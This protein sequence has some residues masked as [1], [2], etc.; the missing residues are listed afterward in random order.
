MPIKYRTQRHPAPGRSAQPQDTRAKKFDSPGHYTD[1]DREKIPEEDF[2]GPGRTYPIVTQGDV[3]D[4]A[5]LIGHAADPAAVKAKVKAIAKR[6]GFSLP[7]SWQEEEDSRAATPTVTRNAAADVQQVGYASVTRIDEGK[8]EV[9]LTATSERRDSFKT[10]F[11]YEASKAAFEAWPGNVREMHAPKAVGNRVAVHFDDEHRKI[12]TTLRI[13][14][15]A[16]DTWQKLLDG[17]LKGGSIG[18]SN[19]VWEKRV[20]RDAGGAEEIPVAVKYDLVELSLVDN[21]SNPDCVITVVRAA[22][23]LDTILDII[24]ETPPVSIPTASVDPL[25]AGLPDDSPQAHIRAKQAE[26]A[27]I[28]LAGERAETAEKRDHPKQ[29]HELYPEFIA[30]VRLAGGSAEAREMEVIAEEKRAKVAQAQAIATPTPAAP[31]TPEVIRDGGGAGTAPAAAPAAGVT[32]ATGLQ[33]YELDGTTSAHVHEHAHRHADG[34]THAHPHVHDHTH[35]AAEADTVDHADHYHIFQGGKPVDARL[36]QAEAT[37]LPK[38]QQGSGATMPAGPKTASVFDNAPASN[39]VKHTQASMTGHRV[40]YNSEDAAA[41][42]FGIPDPEEDRPTPGEDGETLETPPDMFHEGG[43]WPDAQKLTGGHYDEDGDDDGDDDGNGGGD[44]VRDSSR[45]PSASTINPGSMRPTPG[46]RTAQPAETRLGARNSA[47][48]MDA[49]HSN[50]RDAALS[51]AAA[52]CE[53]CGCPSCKAILLVIAPNG[54]VGGDMDQDEDEGDEDMG[55][56]RVQLARVTRAVATTQATVTELAAAN[57]GM[58]EFLQQFQDLAGAVNDMQATVAD[59]QR[60]AMAQTTRAASAQSLQL[61]EVTRAAADIAQIAKASASSVEEMKAQ[62]ARIEAQPLPGGPISSAME[63]KRIATDQR[64][65]S[66]ASTDERVK[67]IQDF[68]QE[69]TRTH[70]ND[71]SLNTIQQAAFDTVFKLTVPQR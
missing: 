62:L 13:S 19:V 29:E 18:A 52:A 16:E 22:Q 1:K 17:T 54:E 25:T 11:N 48:D 30:R 44:D 66:G 67:I 8:R 53:H 9:T 37:R 27:R 15:G 14:K 43:E 61:A 21:P 34:S 24:E 49:M 40:D 10:A 42:D 35:R 7:E 33:G 60:Q 28:R 50:W 65:A 63:L 56:M 69:Y 68:A 32:T 71:P 39:P 70:P 45:P 2:A 59:T 20:M 47:A 23:P 64:G 51:N 5:K 31:T 57:A 26:H 38:S 46:N 6:K 12:D 55:G 36:A 41:K 58:L 3:H 4:A